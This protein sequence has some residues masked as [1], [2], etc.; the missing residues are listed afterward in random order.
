[1]A[2]INIFNYSD[3]YRWLVSAPAS[4]DHSFYTNTVHYSYL[5]YALLFLA[6]RYRIVSSAEDQLQHVS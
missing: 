2:N 6:I 3:V 4:N 5:L 1:M